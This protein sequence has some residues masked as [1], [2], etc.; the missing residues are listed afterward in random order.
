MRIAYLVHLNEGPNSGVYKK[1]V[2]QV[3]SW[4]KLGHTAQLFVI[5]RNPDVSGGL[6]DPGTPI[7]LSEYASGGLRG[8]IGRLQAFH[9]NVKQLLRWQP[10]IMYYREDAWYW[11]V[12]RA[13]HKTCMVLEVN[14]N[15]LAEMK[16]GFQIRKSYDWLTRSLCIRA[17][18]GIVAVSGDLLRDPFLK[19]ISTPHLVLGNGIRLEDIPQ[20]PPRPKGGRTR[21]VF[22]GQPGLRWHGVDKIL[23]LADIFPEW[24]FEIIG[25]TRDQIGEAPPN[26]RALGTMSHCDYAKILAES[27]CA[28]GSLALYRAGIEEASTLKAREYLAHGLPVIIGGRDTDFPDGAR[29]LHQLPNGEVDLK[30][31]E[32]GIRRFVNAWC[33][34][35]VPREEIGHLDSEIK[36]ESRIAFFKRVAA[37][38]A[39]IRLIGAER[40]LS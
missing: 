40:Q 13:A 22:I 36:E 8:A 32:G 14:S 23:L 24:Q 25:Y 35:R 33:G 11:P 19:G 5:T 37:L 28:I 17:A 7:V 18:K 34:Q 30:D 20:L 15:N 10:D 21:L 6:R 38:P 26:V 31:Y 39:D 1:V 3:C 2:R 16:S 29:F 12:W 9:Q 4:R 27:D